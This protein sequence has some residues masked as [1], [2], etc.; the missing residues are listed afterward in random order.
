MVSYL[1]K[2]DSN[3]RTWSYPEHSEVWETKPGQIL[4]RKVNVQYFTSRFIKC[5]IVNDDLIAKMD[6]AVKKF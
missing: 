5:R 1:E 2:C 6:R 4:A 3:G